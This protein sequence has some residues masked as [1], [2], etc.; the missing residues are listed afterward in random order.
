MAPMVES[1]VKP[2]HRKSSQWTGVFFHKLKSIHCFKLLQ[3]ERIHSYKPYHTTWKFYLATLTCFH[4]K[5]TRY[6]FSMNNFILSLNITQSVDPLVVNVLKLFVGGVSSQLYL[7]N[8]F[9]TVRRWRPSTI[10]S[11]SFAQNLGEWSVEVNGDVGE[12][13]HQFIWPVD[14]GYLTSVIL[15]L[16][17]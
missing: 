10:P 7:W 13:V 4:G 9:K 14:F 5:D 16:G 3:S 6:V 8:S 1:S 11:W 17:K 12:T 15:Y 2:I